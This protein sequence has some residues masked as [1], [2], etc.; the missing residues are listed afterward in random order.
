MQELYR[1]GGRRIGVFDVP[2]IG[3]V[4]SQRTLGGGIFRECSNSSNQAA[5]LFNSKLFKEMRTLGKKYSDA[6]FV[7]LESY[8]P[9]MD[10]IQNPSK[11]GKY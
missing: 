11:Y 7:T 5:M 3:C 4:P 2:V 1:L 6:R 9:F 8:Y 10:I